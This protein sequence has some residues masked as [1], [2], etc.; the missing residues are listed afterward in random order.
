MLHCIIWIYLHH[1]LFRPSHDLNSGGHFHAKKICSFCW[2]NVN[3]LK[4]YQ[5]KYQAKFQILFLKNM[6]IMCTKVHDLR[7]SYLRITGEYRT[8]T[9]SKISEQIY[10]DVFTLIIPKILLTLN[11]FLMFLKYQ[12]KYNVILSIKILTFS[13]LHVPGLLQSR[14]CVSDIQLRLHILTD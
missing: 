1:K 5:F 4:V 11:V 6:K 12:S 9:N 14:R 8:V 3:L 13:K 10:L 2:L 7:H